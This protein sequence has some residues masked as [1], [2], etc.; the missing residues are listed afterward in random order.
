MHVSSLLIEKFKNKRD[1]DD[2][3]VKNKTKFFPD[4][5]NNSELN[6]FFEKFW[7]INLK[8]KTTK[9]NPSQKQTQALKYT[10]KWKHNYKRSRHKKCRSHL[11]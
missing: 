6:T 8:E 1:T 10:G 9:N 2:S 7:S 4:K 11:R 3:L 5:N